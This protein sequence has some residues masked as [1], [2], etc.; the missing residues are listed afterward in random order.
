MKILKHSLFTSVVNK[1]RLIH[2]QDDTAKLSLLITGMSGTGKSTLV[3]W[4]EQQ[5]PVE[6]TPE[7]TLKRVICVHL[8][9]PNSPI[10]LLEQII[11]AMG[12]S[13]IPRRRTLNKLLHQL[14]CLLEACQT[15]LIILDEAQ[16]CLPDSD[17][18]KA[19]SMAKA[20]VAI[21]DKCNVPLILIGTPALKRLLK[22]KY[23]ADV[24][25]ISREEQLSRR[26]IAPCQLNIFLSHCDAWVNVINFFGKTKGL[27]N[28]NTKDADILD[29]LYVAT[30]GRIGLI[31]KLFAFTQ[32]NET[33]DLQATFYD[34]YEL[35][36][37]TGEAN[38]FN[39]QDYTY[40]AIIKKAENIERIYFT[41]NKTHPSEKRVADRLFH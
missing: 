18:I 25:N 35:V 5:Y 34:A 7:V 30:Y 24:K 39:Q 14:K 17:G 13:Y 20:F 22:L 36:D 21:I 27:R 10:N 11:N 23:L 19:Q 6:Y 31:K 12:T 32:L 3:D 4:Y 37:T 28:L 15:E 26:F 41:H 33:S 40:A 29:R 16:E 9:K 8:T 1:M 2:H 38:P